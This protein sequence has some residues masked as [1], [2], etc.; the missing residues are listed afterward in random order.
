MVDQLGSVIEVMKACVGALDAEALS[1]EAAMQVFAGFA[2]VERL[3]AA[4]KGMAAGRVA[5][6]EVWRRGGSRSAADGVGRNSGAAPESA[7]ERV[8][9]AGRLADCP[10]VAEGLRA[11]R[12]SVSQAYA[13]VDAVAVRPDVEG[14]VGGV[15]GANS[16]RRVGGGGARGGDGGGLGGVGGG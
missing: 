4:G 3:G 2:E 6:A 10:A 7:K 11:G 16:V 1:G 12:L 13:V 5:A 9:M 15:A 8:E 14:R